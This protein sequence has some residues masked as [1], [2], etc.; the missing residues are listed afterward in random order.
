MAIMSITILFASL[1]FEPMS[2]GQGILDGLSAIGWLVA[3]R[4][5]KLRPTRSLDIALGAWALGVLSLV[6]CT[7]YALAA[8]VKFLGDGPI[9]A[10]A[11]AN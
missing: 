3:L 10:F 11:Q 8:V 7:D 2:T 9:A 6:A 5:R 1:S 4:M